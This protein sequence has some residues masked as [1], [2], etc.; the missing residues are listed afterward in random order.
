[1]RLTVSLRPAGYVHVPRVREWPTDAVI[2]RHL[3]SRLPAAFQAQVA[4]KP[5]QW[6]RLQRE[7]ETSPCSWAHWMPSALRLRLLYNGSR[8]DVVVM[9]AGGDSWGTAF[10]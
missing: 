6:Q 5:A 4:H 9:R 8:E 7:G 2:I 1:M 10:G 3:G